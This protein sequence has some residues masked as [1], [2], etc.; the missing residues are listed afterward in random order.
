VLNGTITANGDKG[1]YQTGGGA[2]GGIHVEV[3]SLSGAGSFQVRGENYY[4]GGYEN[5]GG[6]RISVYYDTTNTFTGS[7]GTGYNNN[8]SASG[9]GTA[10]VKQ[11]SAAYGQLLVDNNNH[12]AAASSTPIRRVG[13]QLI[14]GVYRVSGSQWRIE[15]ANN[16]WRKTDAA[17]DWGVDG[18]MV[19]L[20]A[21]ETSSPL[22]RIVSNTANTITINTSDNLAGVV[23]QE[24]I[25]VQ[26]FDRLTVTRGASIDFG[27]DRVVILNP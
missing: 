13:R 8:G 10:F 18:L 7:Y 6:G 4:Y 19:D 22:Y 3:G 2:G 17:L 1:W 11:T 5:G 21:S 15:V 16:P 9:A 23:G 27:G 12:V 14:T 24:L 20:D 25:G 26:T